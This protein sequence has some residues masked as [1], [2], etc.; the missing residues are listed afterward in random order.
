[1]A[2]LDQVIYR[3]ERVACFFFCVVMILI[4]T[5][6]VI[7]R[8]CFGTTLMVGVQELAMWAFIWMVTMACA[9]LVHTEKTHSG[10]IFHADLLPG[11]APDCDLSAHRI[12]SDFLLCGHYLDRVPVCH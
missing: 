4:V 9:A 10:G 6:E 2:R 12:I 8:Y 1:M 11:Q 3:V 7:S 5:A